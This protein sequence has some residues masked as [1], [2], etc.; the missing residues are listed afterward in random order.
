MHLNSRMTINKSFLIYYVSPIIIFVECTDSIK[1]LGSWHPLKAVKFFSNNFANI[2]YIKLA[3]FKKNN[4]GFCLVF[5]LLIFIIW[6][7]KIG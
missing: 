2:I 7:N 3:S 1:N 5:H 6:F 4:I